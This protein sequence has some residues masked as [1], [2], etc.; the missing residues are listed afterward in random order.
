M[1][2]LLDAVVWKLLGHR[3]SLG[4]DVMA[5][6]VDVDMWLRANCVGV[7]DFSKLKSLAPRKKDIPDVLITGQHNDVDWKQLLYKRSYVQIKQQLFVA[8]ACLGLSQ[9]AVK[10]VDLRLIFPVLLDTCKKV[11]G[12]LVNF[13]FDFVI[14]G[15]Q[16]FDC[17]FWKG[18]ALSGA[19]SFFESIGVDLFSQSKCLLYVHP[20]G[21]NRLHIF[22]L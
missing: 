4:L 13:G 15:S 12:S 6:L 21:T 20:L 3:R 22:W 14:L 8:K 16:E 2:G 1:R 5:Y 7:V 10:K 18:L 9:K 11:Q 19:W 17:G